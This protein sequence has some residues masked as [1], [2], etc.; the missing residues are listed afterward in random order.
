MFLYPVIGIPGLAVGVAVGAFLH[1]GIQIPFLT[2]ENILPHFTWKIDWLSIKAIVYSS[3]PRTFTL[4]A[5]QLASFV[6]VSLASL[7]AS[8]SISVFNFAFNLQSVPLTIIGASYSSA[9]F[10]SLSRLFYQKNLSEFLKKM[11]ISAQHIIF[12]SMPIFFA[13]SKAAGKL[14]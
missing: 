4:S 5:N 6:L 14:P 11:I 12:W 8:G 9:V 2:S 10:P 3:L 13:C 1:M 7:M